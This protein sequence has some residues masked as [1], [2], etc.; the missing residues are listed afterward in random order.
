[1]SDEEVAELLRHAKFA[2]HQARIAMV[3]FMPERYIE[4]ATRDYQRL[5]D[6]E[7]LIDEALEHLPP[8]P[9]LTPEQEAEAA[10]IIRK[11]LER[12]A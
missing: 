2:M 12:F 6:V 10:D 11:A 4:G 9:P 1:M 3:A 5:E 7:K 8:E